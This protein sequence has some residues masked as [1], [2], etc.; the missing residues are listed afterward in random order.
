[1]NTWGRNISI[2]VNGKG[3]KVGKELYWRNSKKARV[4]LVK[5]H[6]LRIW[7]TETG[8]G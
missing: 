4:E 7:V 5:E 6:V 8:K 2:T 1:M 3:P